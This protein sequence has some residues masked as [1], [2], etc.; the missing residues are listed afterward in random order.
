MNL[1]PVPADARYDFN[2]GFAFRRLRGILESG[3]ILSRAEQRA[4]LGREFTTA[5]EGCFAGFDPNANEANWISLAKNTTAGTN[6]RKSPRW[7]GYEM[8]VRDFLSIMVD[9]AVEEQLEKRTKYP[10]LIP[11]MRDEIQIANEIPKKYFTG[12]ALGKRFHIHADF[13]NQMQGELGYD[14]PLYDT[15]E[16]I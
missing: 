8:F 10:L 15:A 7:Y 12:L 2:P 13:V 6:R 9:G 14:L 1:D 5:S 11:P 4:K 3:A 16:I